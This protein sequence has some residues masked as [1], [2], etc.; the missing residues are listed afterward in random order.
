MRRRDLVLCF[1]AVGCQAWRSVEAA[2]ERRIWRV[3]FLSAANAPAHIEEDRIGGFARGMKSL[4]YVEGENLHIEW[5]FADGSAE[6]LAALASQLARAK[7]DVIVTAGVPPTAAAKKATSTIPIVMGTATDPVGSGL[8]ESLASPGGNVTGLSNVSVDI[9]PK[10]FQLLRETVGRMRRVGVLF[11]RG[12][13]SHASILANIQKAAAAGGVTTVRADATASNEIP[14]RL[15]DLKQADTDG[16]IVPL[17]PLFNQESGLIA[18]TCL[19]LHLP[20]ISGFLDY[21]K[22]GGLMAYGQNLAE[23]YF[24]AAVYVDKILRGANP[25]D[26]PIEQPTRLD[27]IVNR[28]TARA[29]RIELPSSLLIQAETIE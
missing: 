7:V 21:A 26:L 29:L 6:K 3:G 19:Q 27:T 11:D 8:V 25:R 28:S 22:L 5:L 24:H 13:S 20:S 10:Q 9:G 23:H 4:G 1:T 2:Q 14:A 12:T 17:S 16:V 15:G 18:R